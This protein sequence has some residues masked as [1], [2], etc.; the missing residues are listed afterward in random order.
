MARPAAHSQARS[1]RSPRLAGAL[2]QHQPNIPPCSSPGTSPGASPRAF[3]LYPR[4]RLALVGL[5]VNVDSRGPSG[6]GTNH[7]LVSTAVTREDMKSTTYEFFILAISILS[8]VNLVW[9]AVLPWGSQK[10]WLVANI[11][12]ALARTRIAELESRA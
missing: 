11:D 8:I 1:H 4:P 3:P 2:P 6:N 9:Y 7:H 12:I 10:W 5:S